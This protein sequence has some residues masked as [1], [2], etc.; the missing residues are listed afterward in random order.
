[1]APR[2][3]GAGEPAAREGRNLAAGGL[4]GDSSPVAR[5][6]DNREVP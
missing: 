2:V 1:M 5:F 6:L 3:D 4:G